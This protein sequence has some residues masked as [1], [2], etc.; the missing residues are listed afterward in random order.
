MTELKPRPSW[1]LMMTNHDDDYDKNYDN[2]D[3]DKN[4]DNDDD[5]ST[6]DDDDKDDGDDHD[7]DDDDK[8]ADTDADAHTSALSILSDG[9]IHLFNLVYV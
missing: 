2:D 3:D 6:N 1:M 9:C 5:D 8:E 7:D 4:D